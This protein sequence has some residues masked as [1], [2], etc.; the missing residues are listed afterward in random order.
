M[1]RRFGLQKA[2]PRNRSDQRAELML[3][4][5]ACVV[6]ALIAGMIVF[7]FAKAWPSFSHNGLDWFNPFAG[8]NVDGKPSNEVELFVSGVG[9]LSERRLGI[10]RGDHLAVPLCDETVL[11][12]GGGDGAEIY[13]GAAR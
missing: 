13:S 1:R 4:A 2:G 9:F 5:L 11:V 10:P 8:G 7:V 3:G 12:T 6:L